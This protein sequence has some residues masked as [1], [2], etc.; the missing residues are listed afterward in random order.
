[1]PEDTPPPRRFD[2]AAY[3]LDAL[4]RLAAGVEIRDDAFTLKRR[5]RDHHWFS[6]IAREALAGRVADLVALPRRVEEVEAVAAACARLRIPLVARGAGTGTYGQAVPL[7][8]GV[9]LD[10][11]GLD[12]VLAADPRRVRAE[13]GA[14][15][16]A[17]DAAARAEG[18]ELR[19]H[20]ST[21]RMATIGG[22]V[23]GGSGGVGSV[24]W[25]GLR[26]PGNLLGATVVTV[27]E[28]PRRLTLTGEETN[29]VNRTFGATGIVVDVALP[30]APA[31][32]WRDLAAVFPDF[33]AALDAAHAVADDAAI[34]KKLV[35]LHAPDSARRLHPIAERIPEGAAAV[36]LMVAAEDRDAA[37]ARLE[38]AAGRVVLER[39]TAEAE[40]DPRALPLYE[41]SWG[42]T[43]LH[44]IRREPGMSYLQ[45][46]F[47]PGRIKETA[48]AMHAAF[49]AELPLHMEFI[50]YEGALAANG[51]QLWPYTSPERLA[52]IIAIHEAAGVP[53]ANPHVFTVE[54]GSR[55]KRV[56]GDQLAFKAE[57]DPH[58][59]LNP[60]KMTSYAPVRP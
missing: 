25:G 7:E 40:A 36:L 60:G 4:R 13:A 15:I 51:A 9:V 54:E 34:A 17:V 50:R 12:R 27:E 37:R 2:R 16:D 31:R 6:P 3:D 53:V 55:H 19:M 8:G 35:S 39:V 29:L 47:P 10:L 45:T 46:L 20:P 33:D 24:A 57:V 11:S 48:R 21:K 5:S 23:C 59:L 56:P 52:E 41:L 26:E 58:G 49:G 22:Y 44:A 42:H 32:D 28:T 43:T 30:L 38:A 14:R 18:G 1:M